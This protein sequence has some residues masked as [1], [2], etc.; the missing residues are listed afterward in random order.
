VSEY[1]NI[2]NTDLRVAGA[3]VCGHLRC[4]NI[5]I[6]HNTNL[7]VAGATVCGHLRCLDIVILIMQTCEVRVQ[8][9]VDTRGVRIL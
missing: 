8:L 4:L 5:V 7:R 9:S 2:N 1:C 3:T 6:L